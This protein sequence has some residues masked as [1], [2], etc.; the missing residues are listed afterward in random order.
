MTKTDLTEREH[1]L[2]RTSSLSSLDDLSPAQLPNKSESDTFAKPAM[3][4]SISVLPTASSSSSSPSASSSSN[5]NILE[6]AK[7]ER[8]RIHAVNELLTT[9]EDYVADLNII[10]EEFLQPMRDQADKIKISRE[11]IEVIFSCV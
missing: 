5:S 3:Q 1:Q 8:M 10:I 11:S 7:N 9:E 4:R 2:S 6:T